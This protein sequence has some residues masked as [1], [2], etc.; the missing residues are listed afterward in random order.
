MLNNK[1]TFYVPSTVAGNQAISNDDLNTRTREIASIFSDMFGG[2]SI[3]DS[4]GGWNSS[5]H[6]LI[7][8]NVKQVYSYA[9]NEQ[10]KEHKKAVIALANSKRVEWQQEAISV[11]I[12]RTQGGLSFV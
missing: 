3:V 2:F 5:E 12:V 1:I 4:V 9:S 8:E 6:G 11:E 7:L 10:I